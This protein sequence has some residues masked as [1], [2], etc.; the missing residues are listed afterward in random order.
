MLGAQPVVAS[1]PGRKNE[2]PAIVQPFL[3]CLHCSVHYDLSTLT[4]RMMISVLLSLTW[5][6]VRLDN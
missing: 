3:T 4:S 6:R 2:R 5:P 1:F